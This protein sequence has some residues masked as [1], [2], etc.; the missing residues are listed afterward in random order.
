MRIKFWLIFLSLV[1]ILFGGYL[2]YNQLSSKIVWKSE[3]APKTT[4]QY[5][6]QLDGTGAASSSGQTPNVV[7]V[8]IDNH[9]DAWPP[10]GL[11]EARVVYEAPAEGGITRFFAIFDRAQK[12][13]K[14]GPVRSA[15]AYYLDWLREYGEA[16]YLHSGGSPEALELIKRDN[17]FDANE[18]YNGRYY[19]RSAER[20]APHNLYTSSELWQ[21]FLTIT[22]AAHGASAWTGWKFGPLASGTSSEPVKEI[23]LNY[24]VDYK[25]SWKFDASVGRYERWVNGQKFITAEGQ[26]VYADNVLI[27]LTE[28]KVIDEIGRRAI[29]TVGAGE[30]RVLREGKMIRGT[31]KKANPA[32]RT[33]FYDVNSQ[34]IPLSAG[35]TWVQIVPQNMVMEVTN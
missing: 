22:S 19:W 5:F 3:T 11:D 14:V 7:G 29:I 18:F 15:R 1:A 35:Q 8:M 30:G 27:Q 16:L 12:V 4:Y 13:A 31:W 6:S 28:M 23:T 25:V 20:S 24:F 2:L 17:I 21:Q 9:P 32:D 26:I 10:S 34:E 33:K